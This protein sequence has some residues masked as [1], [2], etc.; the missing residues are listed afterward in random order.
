[1]AGSAFAQSTFTLSFTAAQY[2][3]PENGDLSVQ[4]MRTG[5]V[6]DGT[7]I[8]VSIREMTTGSGHLADYIWNHDDPILSIRYPQDDLYYNPGRSYLYKI[9]DTSNLGVF[10]SPSSAVLTITDDEQAPRVSISDG[11]IGKGNATFGTNPTQDYAVFTI[12]LSTPIFDGPFVPLIVHDGSAKNGVDYQLPY[13][14][15]AYGGEFP[16]E[17]QTWTTVSIPILSTNVPKTDTTFTVELV[18]RAP[19]LPGRVIG[20]CTIRN[21]S[22]VSPQHQ[23]LFKGG[24]GVVHIRLGDAAVSDE[25]V[26]FL[27]TDQSLF[28]VPSSVTIAAGTSGADVEFACPKAGSGTILAT[29]PPSRG[30]RTLPLSVS[31][32]DHSTVT[33]D[34]GRL[35]LALG[36][37]ASVTAHVDPPPPSPVTLNLLVSS[38]GSI[39]TPPS[40]VTGAGGTAVIPVHTLAVGS[41]TVSVALPDA[42][43]GSPATIAVSVTVGPVITLVTPAIGRSPGG[44]VVWLYGS[45][46]SQHCAIE[47]GGIPVPEIHTQP[48]GDA[49]WLYTPPHDG[50]LVD[51]SIRC[52]AHQFLL[53]SSFTYQAASPLPLFASPRFGTTRGGTIVVVNGDGF[54]YNSCSVR[55]GETP[56]SLLSTV[57]TEEIFVVAPPHEA[58]TVPVTVTCRG[59]MLAMGGVFEYV[60]GDDGL[61]NILSVTGDFRS[62]GHGQIAAHALRL[63]DV[64]LV[65]G[66]AVPDQ[67]TTYFG[68]PMHEF[69]FPEITG[70]VELR[71]RDYLGRAFVKTIALDPEVRS[72]EVTTPNRITIGA[73][74]S[75]TARNLGSGLKYVLGGVTLQAITSHLPLFQFGQVCLSCQP[76]T[77]VLRAPVSLGPGTFPLTISDRNGNLISSTSVDL[78]T[79][80]I[81]ASTITPPC[82]PLEGGSFVAISGSGFAEGA[83]V[84][85]GTTYSTKVV[86]K[87]PLTIIAKVPPA[88]GNLRPQITVVNPDGSEATQTNAF[89]YKSLSDGACGDQRHHAAGALPQQ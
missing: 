24:K 68:V 42:S 1:M 67:I 75:A 87:D 71:L 26:M 78:V 13:P 88:Y 82:G 86:V 77:A 81:V 59:R 53:P 56:V 17:G 69:E 21:D 45:N 9:V 70:N 37:S 33:V 80:G 34:P 4:L 66:V 76:I 12:T 48:A 72:G 6:P 54:D 29:M 47:F 74:F 84:A 32:Y 83:L 11:V 8:K 73:E 3:A 25:Q 7:H 39:S 27:S 14:G 36:S 85:F 44:D 50:G 52:G 43:G 20:H 28:T 15:F 16:N 49:I 65:N 23:S 79:S 5:T 30:G 64:V 18:P 55:F 57:G 58:G 38:G 19:I 89:T 60:T 62:G 35:D 41:G 63:D 40:V 46:F 31:V 51:I 2:I 61:A 22:A 10:G